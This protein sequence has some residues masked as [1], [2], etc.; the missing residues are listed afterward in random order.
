MYTQTSALTGKNC[1]TAVH[2]GGGEF[3]I[4]GSRTN[5][6]ES[7]IASEGIDELETVDLQKYTKKLKMCKNKKDLASTNLLKPF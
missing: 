7:S 1:T 3:S 5:N 2:S 6:Y 4:D